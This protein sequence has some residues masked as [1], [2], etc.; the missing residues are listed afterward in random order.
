MVRNGLSCYDFS[1]WCCISPF[2][3]PCFGFQIRQSISKSM[4]WRERSVILGKFLIIINT[5]TWFK[6]LSLRTQS[7][8]L[9]A[10]CF[11]QSELWSIQREIFPPDE[12]LKVSVKYFKSRSP[13]NKLINNHALPHTISNNSVLYWLPEKRV[14]GFQR[15]SACSKREE[16][17]EGRIYR[18]WELRTC[19]WRC[20]R[21]API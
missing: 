11:N 10:F 6:L 5:R 8:S 19:C 7:F 14:G 12:G 9:S 4:L 1:R 21:W 3:W 13:F 2:P 15:A 18:N 20:G 16:D 17:T